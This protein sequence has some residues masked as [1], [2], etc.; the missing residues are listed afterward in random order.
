MK[1]GVAHFCVS[2]IQAFFINDTTTDGRINAEQDRRLDRINSVCIAP[3]VSPQFTGIGVLE[4]VNKAAGDFET[5]D[6]NWVSLFA[7][8]LSIYVN[9][10]N[11]MR[12]VEQGKVQL[13]IDRWISPPER[14]L[15]ARPSKVHEFEAFDSLTFYSPERSNLAGTFQIIFHAFERF[16]LLETFRIT[17][18]RLFC[19]IFECHKLYRDIPYHN[20]SKI[21]DMFQSLLFQ[22]SKGQ[23]TDIFTPNELL[24]L[25]CATL[26]SF[27]RHDGTSNDFHIRAKTPIGILYREDPLTHA[28]CQAAIRI[29]SKPT[30]NL[31]QTLSQNDVC[32]MWQSIIQLI[33]NTDD[34]LTQEKV[35]NEC[36][37][38]VKAGVLDWDNDRHRF[39]ML[40]MLLKCANLTPFAR[41]FTITLKWQNAMMQEMF[42]L[43]NQEMAYGI[44]YSSRHNSRDH[45]NKEQSQI[46]LLESWAIPVFDIQM[47][48]VNHLKCFSEGAKDNLIKWKARLS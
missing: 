32:Q 35:L 37:K 6:L 26:F 4:C 24:S 14:D 30:C 1:V 7:S 28:H 9:Q 48:M 31:F 38:L 13:E 42:Y 10:V 27:A 44:D 33:Q 47:M 17:N 21:I 18:T 45:H 41:P 36:L 25:F 40:I 34:F 43:G 3:I 39:L 46:E 20:W 22:I 19:V 2:A 23:L 5:E 15:I 12:V 16:H 29:L 8:M 11:L